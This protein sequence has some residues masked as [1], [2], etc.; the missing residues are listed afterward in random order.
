[1]ALTIIAH[2]TLTKRVKVPKLSCAG[3]ASV[4]LGSLASRVEDYVSAYASATGLET[5]FRESCLIVATYLGSPVG[6]QYRR[7][8]AEL[9]R[10]PRE[11]GQL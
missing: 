3:T 5:V 2:S 8:E 4:F 1:M 10:S 9:K 7:R 6:L 11:S